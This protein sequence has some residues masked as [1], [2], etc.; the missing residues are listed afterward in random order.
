MKSRAENHARTASRIS[1]LRSE[2]TMSKEK[3]DRQFI[4]S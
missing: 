2:V 4:E 3:L 1:P